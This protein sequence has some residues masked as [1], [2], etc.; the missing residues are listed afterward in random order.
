MM[1]ECL[2]REKEGMNW[3]VALDIITW[4][5]GNGIGQVFS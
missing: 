1:D 3:Q 4:S 5:F 2:V